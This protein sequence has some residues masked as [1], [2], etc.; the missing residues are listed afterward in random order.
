M[1]CRNTTKPQNV[2]KSASALIVIRVHF[3][4]AIAQIPG[5]NKTGFFVA[6]PIAVMRQASTTGTEEGISY[7]FFRSRIIVP[8]EDA[9][10]SHPA[11]IAVGTFMHKIRMR[12]SFTNELVWLAQIQDA[13]VASHN[14]PVESIN[15]VFMKAGTHVVMHIK[16]TNNRYAY[17]SLNSS[18]R[19][20]LIPVVRL[21]PETN[22]QV[23]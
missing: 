13:H 16:A 23:A 21:H 15:F 3:I 1:Y 5:K 6:I 14:K 8:S 20:S 18:P 7:S 2:I 9:T 22:M 11:K 12:S 19:I 10:M 17:R 4:N